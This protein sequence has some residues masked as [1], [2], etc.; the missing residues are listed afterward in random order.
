ML[1]KMGLRDQNNGKK[2]GINGSRIYHVTTLTVR[3]PSSPRRL[4]TPQIWNLKSPPIMVTPSEL[5]RYPL[6]PCL[7]PGNCTHTRRHSLYLKARQSNSIQSTGFIAQINLTSVKQKWLILYCVRDSLLTA[8]L[9]LYYPIP[10]ALQGNYYLSINYTCF[11][12]FRFT[13]SRKKSIRFFQFSQLSVPC[14]HTDAD[15]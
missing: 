11:C 5:F 12:E 10:Y 2:V 8:S 15:P 9:Q 13:L 14:C 6:N 3:D 4:G 1:G 7:I